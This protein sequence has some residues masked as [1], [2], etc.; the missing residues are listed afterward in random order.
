ML[1]YCGGEGHV[2]KQLGAEI[3]EVD[4]LALPIAADGGKVHQIEV[5]QKN[6]PLITDFIVLF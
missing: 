2:W 1:E 6:F 3:E 5:V 4:G